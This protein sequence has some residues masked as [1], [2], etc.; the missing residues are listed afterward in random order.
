M[1]F[2]STPSAGRATVDG[3]A[4][5][6]TFEISIHALRGEGDPADIAAVTGNNRFQSTPSA[7]RATHIEN[8]SMAIRYISI[9]ALRGEGDSKNAQILFTV[10]L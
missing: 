3:I 5:K 7:G 8:G 9:H 2:Q 4:G 6:A 1:G 10:F